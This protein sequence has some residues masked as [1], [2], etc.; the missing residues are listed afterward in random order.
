MEVP[1]CWTCRRLTLGP[2]GQNYSVSVSLTPFFFNQR[3]FNQPKYQDQEEGRKKNYRGV[4]RHDFLTIS[5]HWQPGSKWN[6]LYLF[7]VLSNLGAIDLNW[8]RI[9]KL[10]LKNKVDSNSA[11]IDIINNKAKYNQIDAKYQQTALQSVPT[12]LYLK[13]LVKQNWCK[14]KGHFLHS[15]S[16]VQSPSKVD[17]KFSKSASHFELKWVLRGHF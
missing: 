7:F 10:R 5:T 2:Q 9:F 14:S 4:V 15:K 17:T 6:D 13:F 12:N 8:E 16:G 1:P 11:K 3:P